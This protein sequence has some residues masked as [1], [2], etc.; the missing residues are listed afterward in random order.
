MKMCLYCKHIDGNLYMTEGVSPKVKC[1]YDSE[2]HLLKE[3]CIKFEEDKER[4]VD[5]V[6]EQP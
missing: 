4:V 6:N 2:Y 5:I 3:L 1:E